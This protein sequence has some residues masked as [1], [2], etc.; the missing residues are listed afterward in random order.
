MLARVLFE[1]Y[2]DGA[3]GAGDGG[4]PRDGC[5]GRNVGGDGQCRIGDDKEGMSRPCVNSTPC[6]GAAATPTEL[7]VSSMLS[8][9]PGGATSPTASGSVLG[10]YAT[11]L[12]DNSL[13]N[14]RPRRLHSTVTNVALRVLPTGTRLSHA[15]M[16]PLIFFVFQSDP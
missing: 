16:T 10:T 7:A 12:L 2:R 5:V 8:T 6:T 4:E 1:K 13:S 11:N 14:T 3:R 15:M 9:S